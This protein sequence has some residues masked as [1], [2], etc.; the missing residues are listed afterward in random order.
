MSSYSQSS[1][2]VG[3]LF[4][5]SSPTT[6]AQRLRLSELA[7]RHRLL[8]IGQGSQYKDATLLAYGANNLDLWRRAATYVDK[9]LKGA[10]PAELPVEQPM[11]Y[12]FT[13]NLQIARALGLTIPE[14]VLLQATEVIQ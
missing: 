10:N 7:T 13:I 11:K 2:Q 1:G 14:S 9:L 4:L 8:S 5:D 6:F 12:D 3:G